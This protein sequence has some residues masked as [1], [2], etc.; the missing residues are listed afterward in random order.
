MSLKVKSVGISIQNTRCFSVW[1]HLNQKSLYETL[2]I[3][4]NASQA[5]V[6][7][8]FYKL[9][10]K[11]H[12]DANI[13]DSSATA[14]F[15][16]IVEAYEILGNEAA[17]K[18]YDVGMPTPHGKANPSPSGFK[19]PEDPQAAF[20]KSRLMNK[21]KVPTTAKTYNFDAWTR[22]HYSASLQSNRNLQSSLNTRNVNRYTQRQQPSAENRYALI[23]CTVIVASYLVIREMGNRDKPTGVK[24]F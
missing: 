7:A 24:K 10:K 14:K 8:A 19:V 16:E 5:D 18:R 11:H 22:E 23:M 3:S 17:R 13:E 12:P 1:N 6:K 21:M 9:S 2:R 15:Q 4:P 20:Y